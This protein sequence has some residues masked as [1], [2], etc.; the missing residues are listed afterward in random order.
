MLNKS[1]LG[2]AIESAR[3]KKGVTKKAMADHFGIKPPSIQDWVKHGRIDKEHLTELF[4]YFSDVVGPDHW[5]LAQD[6][7]EFA[8][9]FYQ[10]ILA[11]LPP[12]ILK[13]LR[14]LSA[15]TPEIQ[16]AS[17]EEVLSLIQQLSEQQKKGS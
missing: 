10:D 16:R 9:V 6:E 12:S 8:Y 15:L 11:K 17:T 14:D 5:G 4:R 1:E 7:A 2:K 13:A 3:K